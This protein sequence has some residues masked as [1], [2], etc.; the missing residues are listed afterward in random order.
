MKVQLIRADEKLSCKV[1]D[2]TF[3]FR[4][5]KAA[6]R[7]AILDKHTDK[8]LIDYSAA[9]REMVEMAMIGWQ[10]VYSGDE[11][12]PFDRELIDSL[13]ERVILSIQTALNRVAE[14]EDLEIGNLLKN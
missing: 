7:R 10:D 11:E 3:F 8:G 6:E 2:S 12:I 13:P 5:L 9:G 1:F 14:K 4:R